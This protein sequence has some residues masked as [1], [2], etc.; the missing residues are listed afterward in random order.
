MN[1]WLAD[2]LL[3][4]L[5]LFPFLFSLR[6]REPKGLFINEY[7]FIPPFFPPLF[8]SPA[9][10]PTIWIRAEGRKE[11]VLRSLPLF[12]LLFSFLKRKWLGDEIAGV[13][14]HSRDIG[15]FECQAVHSFPPFFFLPPLFSSR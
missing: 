8:P 10:I 9:S 11:I 3:S 6:W 15:A 1:C 2:V 12:F 4:S 13:S 7:S 5:S 14:L